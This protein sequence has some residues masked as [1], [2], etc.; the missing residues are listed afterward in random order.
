MH[1]G[2]ARLRAA[3]TQR[4]RQPGSEPLAAL[5]ILLLYRK[6]CKRSKS[7]PSLL[8]VPDRSG[9]RVV[10]VRRFCGAK[11]VSAVVV[12]CQSQGA[13]LLSV[14]PLLAETASR[15]PVSAA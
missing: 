6:P 4:A 15:R 13:S 14:G 10:A 1:A 11:E 2:D 3:G 5:C 9:W 12:L 8:T 7:S